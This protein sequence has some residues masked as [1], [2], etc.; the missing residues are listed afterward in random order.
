M[1]KNFWDKVQNIW[2]RT[3]LVVKIAV[4]GCI[5]GLIVYWINRLN[6]K[7][8]DR[9]E[10][11]D[12]IKKWEESFDKFMSQYRKAISD[13]EDRRKEADDLFLKKKEQK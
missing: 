12:A 11:E 7:S 4:L 6:R 2:S 3:V 8:Q 1:L 9:K 13:W 10:L 5:V